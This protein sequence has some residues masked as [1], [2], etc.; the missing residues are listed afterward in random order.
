MPGAEHDDVARASASSLIASASSSARATTRSSNAIPTET[1]TVTSPDWSAPAASRELG[2]IR[3]NGWPRQR[4][5]RSAATGPP[6]RP[7]RPP[8]SRPPREPGAPSRCR[9]RACRAGTRRRR[10]HAAP[11]ASRAPSNNWR[12]VA[13]VQ[14]QTMF[15]IGDVV[16]SAERA[17]KPS[18]AAAST[19]ASARSRVRETTTTSSTGR[20]ARI[21]S[22]WPGGLH[23]GAEQDEAARAGFARNRVATP[24]TAAVRSAVS[25][26]P[27]MTACG[28]CVVRI[29]QHIDGLDER[30]SSRR[31]RVRQ[32]DELDP[33][34]GAAGRR[35]REQRARRRRG[36]RA[37]R[38]RSR[39][40]PGRER[41]LRARRSRPAWKAARSSSAS[42]TSIRARRGTPDA[43]SGRARGP[44]PCPTARP[45]PFGSRT[46]CRRS[47]TPWTRS[48]PPRRSSFRGRG[49]AG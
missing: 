4:P 9:A 40:V 16:G 49:S 1:N 24:L 17:A 5:R 36:R 25:S 20:T 44:G 6:P 30:Q 19:S 35:H 37:E 13:V 29:E 33:Q 12:P 14:V 8:G 43:S 22:R 38:D 39:R 27:S 28:P 2:E 3:D 23:A 7:P 42:M 47:T 18:P 21:A 11:A 26:V 32:R 45:R 10:S 34:P 15:G 48:A 46:P 41:C 31:V